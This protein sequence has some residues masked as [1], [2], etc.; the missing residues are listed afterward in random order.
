M[1]G[2]PLT[3]PVVLVMLLLVGAL[4]GIDCNE[5]GDLLRGPESRTLAAAALTQ[6]SSGIIDAF[7][8]AFSEAIFGVAVP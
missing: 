1:R 3:A 6:I 7:T 2:G 8:V 5:T 4:A